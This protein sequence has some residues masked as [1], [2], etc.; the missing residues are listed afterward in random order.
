MQLLDQIRII[1]NSADHP[2]PRSELAVA[3]RALGL[4]FPVRDFTDAWDSV[5]AHAERAA[6]NLQEAIQPARP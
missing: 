3:H 2:K 5:R 4:R 6:S 1:R